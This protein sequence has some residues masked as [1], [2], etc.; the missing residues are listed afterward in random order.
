MGMSRTM[1]ILSGLFS[2]IMGIYG[3]LVL[4][5]WGLEFRSWGLGL[6]GVK[7]FGLQRN[8]KIT[9]YGDDKGPFLGFHRGK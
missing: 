7:R 5:L 1:G 8:I 6:L 4:R 9:T 3:D 2:E